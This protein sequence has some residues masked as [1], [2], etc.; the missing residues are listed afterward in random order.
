MPFILRLL[1]LTFLRFLSLLVVGIG[2]RSIEV[3]PLPD[4]TLVA[5]GYAVQLL[6]TYLFA[7]RAFRGRPY[8]TSDTF[9]VFIAFIGLG[10]L[11][12]AGL[13]LWLTG[14]PA[15]SVFGTFNRQSVY[16]ILTYTIAIALASQQAKHRA[17]TRSNPEGLSV[18]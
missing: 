13:Y 3:S 11:Y 7:L 12:E 10:T 6:I 1:V 18:G 9:F 2:L 8:A 15:I 5:F 17:Q 14:A 16:L 4:W